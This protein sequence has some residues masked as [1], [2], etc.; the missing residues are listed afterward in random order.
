MVSAVDPLAILESCIKQPQTTALY[1]FP[2]KALALDQM[3]KLQSLVRAMPNNR[4][5]MVSVPTY[6]IT[7][8]TMCAVEMKGKDGGSF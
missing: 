3:R 1:I 5:K 2:L 6:C 7:I 8:F 4:L